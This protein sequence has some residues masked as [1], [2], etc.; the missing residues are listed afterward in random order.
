MKFGLERLLADKSLAKSFG[1]CGL[2]SNQASLL[3]GFVPSWQALMQLLSKDLTTLFSPQHGFEATVQDNMIETAHSIHEPSGRRLYSLYSE[4][5]EPTEK[6]LAD[7]DTILVDIQLSGCRVYTFKYTIA[8]CLRAAKK[9]QKKVVILDRPN[10]LGGVVVEGSVLSMDATSFVGEF[11]IPMRHGLTAAEIALL[12]N[13]DIGADLS[14][15]AMQGWQPEK[16]F[17][18]TGR[19]WIPTSPNLPTLESAL[20]YPGT[21]LLEGINASEGRG[22]TLPFQLVGAPYVPSQ[23]AFVAKLKEILGDLAPQN[24]FRPAAFQPTSQKWSGKECRGCQIFVDPCSADF[25]SYAVGLAVMRAF[26]EFGGQSRGFEWKAPPYEYDLETLPIK[27]IMGSQKADEKLLASD[28]SLND[29][30]W[31]EGQKEYL[32]KTKDI[33]LYDRQRKLV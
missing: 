32:D 29:P 33:L 30:F 21:V 23:D 5:R 27:L 3:E 1:R 26:I 2:L 7:V 17:S 6:M 15:I 16:T 9:Y 31:R 19:Y 14:C 22:T 24:A 12:F 8:A 18:Q 4:T 25:P 28:F 20:V 13:K 11:P 10:P